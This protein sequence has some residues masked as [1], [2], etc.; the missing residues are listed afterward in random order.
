MR[1]GADA[2]PVSGQR[3]PDP[4]QRRK[5]AGRSVRAKWHKTPLRIAPR[6]P[7]APAIGPGQ[8]GLQHFGGQIRAV[9]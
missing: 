7:L 4:G 1:A 5:P 8:P 9:G 2:G 6:R 3:R